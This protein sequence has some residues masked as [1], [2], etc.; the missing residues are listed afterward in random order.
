MVRGRLQEFAEEG[1]Y[2]VLMEGLESFAALSHTRA[3][4][5][6]DDDNGQQRRLDERTGVRY[7]SAMPE[8]RVR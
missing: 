2:R 3:S 4:V 7:A 1:P 5:E 8:R 6:E